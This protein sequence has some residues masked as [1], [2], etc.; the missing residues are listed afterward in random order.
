[1]PHSRMTCATLRFLASA[2]DLSVSLLY[3]GEPLL[4]RGEYPEQ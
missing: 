3:S 1:M 4:P 2:M